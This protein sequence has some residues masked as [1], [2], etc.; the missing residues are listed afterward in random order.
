MSMSPKSPSHVVENISRRD[1]LLL[2]CSLS[3][4]AT[5]FPSAT[6]GSQLMQQKPSADQAATLVAI[7]L[8][9]YATVIDFAGPWE[10]FQDAVGPSS[11]LRDQKGYKLFTVAATRK[12]IVASAG[13]TI[14]PNF[15][16]ADAPQ[17]AIVVVGAQKGSPQVWD[18]LKTSHSRADLTMSV[19]TGA[20]QLARAGLL[21]GLSATTHHDFY[22]R[23]AAQFPKV[24][25][26]RGTRFVDHGRIATAGGLTSG[27][28]LALHVIAR[29][30]GP[31][32][33]ER[34][35]SYMEY[36]GNPLGGR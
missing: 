2:G 34:T 31:E 21:D 18:Y 14:V 1:A 6:F 8:S 3:V 20:F 35:A 4:G 22:D 16:F 17:P 24:A 5:V 26:I 10:V 9:E 19:C 15:T 32:A 33:A 23:F 27:L 12:P 29:R 7:V 30:M 28:D 13:L 11:E 25:L 36:V